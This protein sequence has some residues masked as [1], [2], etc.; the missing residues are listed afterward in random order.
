MS[1]HK[2]A[3]PQTR[4][5]TVAIYMVADGPTADQALDAVA[6]QELDM[7]VHAATDRGRQTVDHIYVPCSSTS[8]TRT[9]SFGSSPMGT[10]R[11]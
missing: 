8:A 6:A 7:I 9:E 3:H 2:K 11:S 1:T 4:D 5:W 10:S